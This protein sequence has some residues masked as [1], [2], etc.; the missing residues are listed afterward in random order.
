MANAAVIV[1]IDIK[2]EGWETQPINTCSPHSSRT[3]EFI[4]AR[5]QVFF[6]GI[7]ENSH[8]EV[9]FEGK[10]ICAC[11]LCNVNYFYLGEFIAALDES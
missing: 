4:M 5:C 3:Q 9:T 7:R 11:T 2:V 8:F 1:T 6:D 10:N